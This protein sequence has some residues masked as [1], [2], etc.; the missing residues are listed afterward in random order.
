ME[1]RGTAAISMVCF[2][3]LTSVDIGLVNSGPVSRYEEK[4]P[5]PMTIKD[6][7]YLAA[8]QIVNRY[9][10]ETLVITAPPNREMTNDP[11]YLTAKEILKKTPIID[12]H[13]DLPW[14]LKT[15]FNNKLKHFDLED[16]KSGMTSLSKL[17]E[18]GLGGQFWAAYVGCNVQ[19]KDSVRIFA[20]QI[21]VIKR[22]V[23]KYPKKLEFVTSVKGLEH[24]I[25]Q[26]K[27]ASMVGME[28]GHGMDNSLGVLRML[29]DLGTRYMT[30]T[31]NC[32]TPWAG[33]ATTEGE[34]KNRGITDFG[35]D[36]INEMNRLGMMVDLSHV[37]SHTM[38]DVLKMT[39]AP[40]IFSHSSARAI[41]EV[42]R[43]VPDDVLK[44]VA[45]NR[46]VVMV[47]FYSCFLHPNCG[48][49]IE[50]LVEHINH[51]RKVAGVD[52]VGLGSDYNGVSEYPTGMEDESTYPLLF[53]EL[54]KQGWNE[55]DLGK[56]ASKNL[57]R[58]WNEVE[59]VRDSMQDEDPVEILIDATEL[60]D[61]TECY[62]YFS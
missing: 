21:D 29:Y 11:L 26:G 22:L 32:D 35:K 36:V 28:S 58:V 2:V 14:L 13:N 5:F 45:Q 55:E 25:E 37:S 51:I 44:M 60:G 3:A 1:K 7:Q 23:K 6:S 34:G 52:C 20:E 43:N 62:S 10:E 57:I 33:S 61:N 46:G 19:F 31:H 8:K 24:A 56:L 4:N 59:A 50:D 15:D 53:V 16:S 39:K 12:G 30:L 38:R 9:E 18:G 17:K 41:N 40:V 54:L 42:M 49:K 47:N 27:F 48:A